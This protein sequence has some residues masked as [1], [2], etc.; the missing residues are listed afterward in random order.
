MRERY[1]RLHASAGMLMDRDALKKYEKPFVAHSEAETA[2]FARDVANAVSPGDIIALTGDLGAGKTA[3]TK[4]VAAGLGVEDN[5]NSP[6]FTIVH[7]YTNG[8]I[9]LYHFDVYRLS[10]IEEF[11]DIGAEEYLFGSGVCIIEWADKV[12]EAIPGNALLIHIDYGMKE[13]ERIYTCV[14]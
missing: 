11:Y 12:S 4:A 2:A 6:T 3:F 10:N 9:P 13:G 7:E 1:I 5:V 8:R 14:F